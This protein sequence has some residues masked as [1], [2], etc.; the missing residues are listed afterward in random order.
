[1]LCLKNNAINILPTV[2][3]FGKNYKY[4]NRQLAKFQHSIHIEIY[5]YI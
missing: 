1:M 4:T 2:A 5:E 3:T